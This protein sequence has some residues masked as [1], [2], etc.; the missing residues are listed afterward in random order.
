[1]DCTWFY[2]RPAL[3]LCV[4]VCVCVCACMCV[5]VHIVPGHCLYM[6]R[7]LSPH[8]FCICFSVLSLFLYV[9][10]LWACHSS[11]LILLCTHVFILLIIPCVSSCFLLIWFYLVSSHPLLNIHISSC[12]ISSVIFSF[13]LMFSPLCPFFSFCLYSSYHFVSSCL[14]L[15]PYLF[16]FLFSLSHLCL[17]SSVV[18]CHLI[19]C[20]LFS[21]LLPSS[22][23]LF[24]DLFLSFCLI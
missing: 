18:S 7:S 9:F 3:A 8:F 15:C 6:Q 20:H 1:M 12:F 16:Y 22:S 17:V 11:F 5:S 23:Y 10:L 19:F 14:I 21:S 13:C 24:L 4:C 2:K